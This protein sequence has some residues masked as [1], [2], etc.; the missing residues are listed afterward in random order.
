MAEIPRSLR[1]RW[2]GHILRMDEEEPL[3]QMVVRLKKPYPPGSLLM[4]APQHTT[5]AD[6]IALA[7]DHACQPRRLGHPDIKVNAVEEIVADERK[8]RHKPP[9]SVHPMALRQR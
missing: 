1:L 7:G 4:D 3:R 8:G 2:L 5:M 9:P 6:L